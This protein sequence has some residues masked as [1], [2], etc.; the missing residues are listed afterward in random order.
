MY[1][2]FNFSSK[3]MYS[4]SHD[5]VEFKTYTVEDIGCSRSCIQD[6]LQQNQ[7]FKFKFI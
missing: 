4:V 7:Y 5:K 6:Y 2:P 1:I 3:D